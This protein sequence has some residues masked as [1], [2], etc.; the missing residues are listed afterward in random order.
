MLVDRPRLLF[1]VLC[2]LRFST[3]TLTSFKQQLEKSMK[4]IE[5]IHIKTAHTYFYTA[6]TYGLLVPVGGQKGAYL[7]SETGNLIC[8][9]LKDSSKQEEFEKSLSS[10]LLSNP[11]KGPLFKKFLEF[12]KDT[13]LE[14]D[15]FKKFQPPTG[16]TLIAWSLEANLINKKGDVLAP[17]KKCES[18]PSEEE[19]WKEML[20]VYKRI[21]KTESKG[22]KRLAVRIDEF[23]LRVI[24][25]LNLQ[26]ISGFDLYLSKLMETDYRDLINLYGAPS[27]LL[28]DPNK[29]FNYRGKVYAYISLREIGDVERKQVN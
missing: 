25:A 24:C 2:T 26:S 10:L 7:I 3:V 18:Q 28:Q 1:E 14:K 22:M 12:I 17:I 8:N 23:R 5:P 29:V 15:V 6:T 9:L 16:K 27:H 4:R 13:A 19:F 21:L 11:K 20:S